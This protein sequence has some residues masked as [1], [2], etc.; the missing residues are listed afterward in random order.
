MKYNIHL[1]LLLFICTTFFLL[2]N[3][4]YI[5][6]FRNIESFRNKRSKKKQKIDNKEDFFNLKW[7]TKSKTQKQKDREQFEQDMNA[8]EVDRRNLIK[9][10]KSKGANDMIK[11]FNSLKDGLYDILTY[12]N[13]R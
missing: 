11:K 7:L 8:R 12:N 6:S 9:N 1:L 4:N 3:P 2:T 5:G 13:L 10:V